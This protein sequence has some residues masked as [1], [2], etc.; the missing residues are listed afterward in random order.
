MLWDV[1]LSTYP[2]QCQLYQAHQFLM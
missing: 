1:N 2:T